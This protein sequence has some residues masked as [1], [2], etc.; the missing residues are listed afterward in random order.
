[1]IH[2]GREDMF[3]LVWAKGRTKMSNSLLNLWETHWALLLLNCRNKTEIRA[4][5]KLWFTTLNKTR[6]EDLF[7]SRPVH[8]K[9]GCN[10][11]NRTYSWLMWF[12]DTISAPQQ[13]Q[14]LT[15]D[16]LSAPATVPRVI[17]VGGGGLHTAGGNR[18]R[19]LTLPWR[20]PGTGGGTNSKNRVS[21]AEVRVEMFRE[22]GTGKRR[23]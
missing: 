23:F 5:F 17:P 19:L 3:D 12:L 15:A 1:M 14:K 4:G 20:S 9:A 8:C 21:S 22:K 16:G 18:F 7:L 13:E 6:S 2:T 11:P 10:V